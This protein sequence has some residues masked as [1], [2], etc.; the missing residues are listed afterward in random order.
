MYHNLNVTCHMHL[1]CVMCRVSY[2][3]RHLL[4][5]PTATATATDPLLIPP[6]LRLMG[7]QGQRI[8]AVLGQTN[9]LPLGVHKSRASYDKL[10]L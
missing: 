5:M 6:L 9:M 3:T 10:L 7:P 1:S 8:I 4:P 2:V